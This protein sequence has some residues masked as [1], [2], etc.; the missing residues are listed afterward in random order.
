MKGR[1]YI[2]LRGATLGFVEFMYVD[3]PEHLIDRC[4]IAE[5][6]VGYFRDGEYRHTNWPGYCL[7]FCKVRKKNVE[8]MKTAL[9]NLWDRML[10]LG[11]S[12]YPETCEGIFDTFSKNEKFA[13]VYGK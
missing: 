6:I 9:D 8:K 4:L 7:C 10:L 3:V 5:R 13:K 1:N 11:H 12:D 2:T